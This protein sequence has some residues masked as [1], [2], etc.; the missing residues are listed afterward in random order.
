MVY[1]FLANGFEEIEAIAPIDIMRRASLEVKTVGVTGNTVC[2]AHGIEVGADITLSEV[3]IDSA[4]LIFL[5]GG[6]PGT[7]N[8]MENKAVE[9]IILKAY[10][11]K[12]LI[13][14]ICAAPM[15]LGR[16]NLLNGRKA[17]CFPGFEK[18]L[19]CADVLAD[20]VAVDANIITAKGA[21]AAH[22]LGFKLVELLKD[23]KTADELHSSMQY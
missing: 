16:L 22:K 3:D 1:V 21:G 20:S 9:D 17:V 11:K 19:I 6:M 14:A 15:I 23:K 7:T 8:L 13:A 18:H 12:V 10:D 4:D 5:P 2:G